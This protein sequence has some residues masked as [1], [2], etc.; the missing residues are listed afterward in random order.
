LTTVN[1]PEDETAGSRDLPFCKHLYIERKDFMSDA[2]RKYYR[3]SEGRNVR[4]KSAYIVHC[5]KAIRDENGEVIEVICTYY[6]DS[7]SGQDTSGIKS[8]GTLHWV[9]AKHG[10]PCTIHNYDRLY[11]DPT[12][13]GHDDKDFTEFINPESLVVNKSAIMEPSLNDASPGDHFQFM[14]L[15]YYTRDTNVSDKN[16]IFNLTVSLKEGYKP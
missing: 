5:E 9:S 4:L 3:L 6:P 15:G 1:N 13:D 12:P 14:R 7:K 11:T 2:P 10:L 8:K 16:P